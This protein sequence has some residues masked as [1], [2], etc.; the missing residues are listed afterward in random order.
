[1]S[2]KS[3]FYQKYK[4]CHEYVKAME[5]LPPTYH[6]T[7][8]AKTC[9]IPDPDFYNDKVF[10]AKWNRVNEAEKNMEDVFK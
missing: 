4:A 2:S 10:D 5:D 9:P 1:M 7:D 6:I 3:S 8:M